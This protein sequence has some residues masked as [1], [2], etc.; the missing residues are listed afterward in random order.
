VNNSEFNGEVEISKKLLDLI[1]EKQKG[2]RDDD[3]WNN[4][5][6]NDYNNN[7]ISSEIKN[8][9]ETSLTRKFHI[10]SSTTS[11][12]SGISTFFDPRIIIINP[13]TPLHCVIKTTKYTQQ[14]FR[15]PENQLITSLFS[16]FPSNVSPSLLLQTK[17]LLYQRFYSNEK[18]DYKKDSFFSEEELR[19]LFLYFRQMLIDGGEKMMEKVDVH[20]WEKKEGLIN[21]KGM[22]VIGDIPSNYNYENLS[23]SNSFSSPFSFTSSPPSSEYIFSGLLI[24]GDIHGNFPSFLH[25]LDLV[26]KMMLLPKDEA[27]VVF[28][29]DLI[30]RGERQV[31]F[32]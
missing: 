28:L 8:A 11:I 32:L 4:D 31:L 23:S 6:N 30:D 2:Y 7:V 16:S 29:G 19:K 5:Y 21:N 17:H 18:I 15:N 27:K 22:R 24:V 25:I 1:E 13:S 12:F 9:R 20:F 14:I 3:N 26:D 10:C